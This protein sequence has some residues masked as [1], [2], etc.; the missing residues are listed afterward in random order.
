MRGAAGIVFLAVVILA[1]AAPA[2]ARGFEQFPSEDLGFENLGGYD[3]AEIASVVC[4]SDLDGRVMVNFRLKRDSTRG[5]ILAQVI[6]SFR[7][8][9]GRGREVLVEDA[10]VT[11][12]VTYGEIRHALD[13]KYSG[14][15]KVTIEFLYDGVVFARAFYTQVQ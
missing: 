1:A 5:P 8:S 2:H 6:V 4:C 12:F 9:K 7:H 14:V 13:P 11:S 3:D 15:Y 10:D